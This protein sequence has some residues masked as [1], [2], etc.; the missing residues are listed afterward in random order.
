MSKTITIRIDDKMYRRI[1]QEDI[2]KSELIR[3]SV[4]QYFNESTYNVDVMDVLKDQVEDLKGQRD[5]LQQRLDYFQMPWY[6]R[7]MLPTNKP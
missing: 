3:R 2:S 4:R 1:L 7:L 6:M 5:L